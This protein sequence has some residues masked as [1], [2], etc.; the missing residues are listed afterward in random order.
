MPIVPNGKT[1]DIR[2][3]IDD[4]RH[5]G[6]VVHLICT[7]VRHAMGAILDLHRLSI[8]PAITL[9]KSNAVGSS[10]AQP[11]GADDVLVIANTVRVL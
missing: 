6:V 2:H 3:G 8:Q 11:I 10:A 9:D 7:D 5:R 1:R 4:P